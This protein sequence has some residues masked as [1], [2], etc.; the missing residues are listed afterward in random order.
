MEDT[1][2]APGHWLGGKGSYGWRGIWSTLWNNDPIDDTVVILMTQVGA[3]G[4]FPSLYMIN[5]YVIAI[6][7]VPDN[8]TAAG[9]SLMVNASGYAK[10][11]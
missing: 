9:V 1:P 4:A 3:D 6:W 10:Q 11:R 5:S 2:S 8:V 7:E